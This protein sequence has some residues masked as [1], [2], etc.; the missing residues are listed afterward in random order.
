MLVEGVWPL[1]W[2]L[3]HESCI[4]F[5]MRRPGAWWNILEIATSCAR[6]EHKNCSNILNANCP[7][8]Q[9]LAR[10]A[11]LKVHAAP[12]I[13]LLQI[14]CAGEVHQVGRN[15]R[16]G[17]GSHSGKGGC[18]PNSKFAKEKTLAAVELATLLF[19]FPIQ[20]A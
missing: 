15:G 13:P 18:H 2:H 14:T 3:Q 9:G 5:W 11:A 10:E 4:F 19:E 8:C 6:D 16:V 17:Q 12:S 7:L 20:F 1:Q